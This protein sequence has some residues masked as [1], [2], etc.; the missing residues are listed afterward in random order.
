MTIWW[1]IGAIVVVTVCGVLSWLAMRSWA[2]ATPAVSRSVQRP[3]LSRA[4]NRVAVLGIFSVLIAAGLSELLG[5]RI[6][7][8]PSYSIPGNHQADSDQLMPGS[9][10]VTVVPEG[11]NS[12]GLLKRMLIGNL[13]AGTR[14]LQVWR[15][16][17]RVYTDKL[18]YTFENSKLAV[19]DEIRVK[20]Y[21]LP[22]PDTDGDGFLTIDQSPLW[23]FLSGDVVGWKL[24]HADRFELPA[25]LTADTPLYILIRSDQKDP[26]TG[27]VR[28]VIRSGP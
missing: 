24:I 10:N 5:L 27:F 6:A 7:R 26:G 9:F 20:N 19:E 25:P 18:I 2:T 22:T 12:K 28:L 21:G 3:R 1:L 8:G 15:I 16:E 14:W 17:G 11:R 13:L 4:L 23:L